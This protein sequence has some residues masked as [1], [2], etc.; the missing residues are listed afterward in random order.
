MLR[1]RIDAHDP[2]RLRG[3]MSSS[4][5]NKHIEKQ[6]EARELATAQAYARSVDE[7]GPWK[8]PWSAK[9][10]SAKG[11]LGSGAK[12]GAASGSKSGSKKNAKTGK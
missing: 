12:S 1:D 3:A 4:D 5:W 11:V 10:S 8:E 7:P 2:V 6:R 9:S